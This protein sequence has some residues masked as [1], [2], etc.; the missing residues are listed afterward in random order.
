MLAPSDITLTFVTSNLAKFNEAKVIFGGEGFKLRHVM[1][2]KLEPQSDSPAEIARAGLISIIP[3]ITP[4]AFVEEAG[5]FIEVYGG[6]PGPYSSYVYR[7]LGCQGILKLMQDVTTRRAEFRAVVA[8]AWSRNQFEIFEGS[9]RG[10]ITRQ[11]RGDG[12][13]GFDPIFIPQGEDRTFAEM[14]V[15]DKSSISH[16][17]AAYR[18]MIAWCRSRGSQ[19]GASF[20]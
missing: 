16:R 13:F 7:T 12:G 4:P 17:A 11:V 20:M 14:S 6:F 2:T 5:L 8:L 19:S 3:L 9:V 18:K 1:A 10:E 15:V